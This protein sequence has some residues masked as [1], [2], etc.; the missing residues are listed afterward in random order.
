LGGRSNLYFWIISLVVS[1]LGG[2]ALLTSIWK[3]IQTYRG[4]HVTDSTGLFIL[5]LLISCLVLFVWIAARL[6][7]R[8]RTVPFANLLPIG[9]TEALSTVPEPSAPLPVD[10]QGEIL[11]MYFEQQAYSF[12]SSF[13][14]VHVLFKVRIVNRGPDQATIVGCGLTISLEGFQWIGEI[15]ADIP[16]SW[17]IRRRKALP[18]AITFEDTPI[19]PMLGRPAENEPYPK[20][21]PRIVWLAFSLPT[22]GEEVEFPNAEFAIHL[23]DSLGGTHCIRRQPQVYKKTG[24]IVVVANKPSL[25]SA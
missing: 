6:E 21:I 15:V 9:Q 3:H 10:L 17:R 2:G 12:A 25:P 8:R 13:A 7:V 16:D 4:V 20:G 24:D 18:F 1:A 23:E 19:T 5:C 14:P 22:F 11:E